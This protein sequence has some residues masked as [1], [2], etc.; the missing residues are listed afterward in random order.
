MRYSSGRTHE[1]K[2][3]ALELAM[4]CHESA[5]AMVALPTLV[6]GDESGGRSRDT[7]LLPGIPYAA[8]LA[9]EPEGTEYSPDAE[10]LATQFD[11]L[12]HRQ[13]HFVKLE[14]AAAFRELDMLHARALLHCTN[15]HPI[16]GAS[17]LELFSAIRSRRHQDSGQHSLAPQQEEDG[18]PASLRPAYVLPVLWNHAIMLEAGADLLE[19]QEAYL[20]IQRLL[21]PQH[22]Q[23]MAD[24]DDMSTPL[25]VQHLTAALRG[26]SASEDAD[27]GEEAEGRGRDGR[28]DFQLVLPGARELLPHSTLATHGFDYKS[29]T[30]TAL[31]R[32]ANAQALHAE[33]RAATHKSQVS[34]PAKLAKPPWFEKQQVEVAVSKASLLHRGAFRPKAPHTLPA[35]GVVRRQTGLRMALPIISSSAS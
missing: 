11:S 9:L 34:N 33:K 35:T 23:V 22:A 20:L 5:Q 15:A 1:E 10:T 3:Q 19:A 13:Y 17:D 26:E 2:M 25:A 24:T 12:Q 27:K 7:A 14:Q 29:E 21:Q 32:L 30:A 16:T 8:R 4:Q 18:R 6:V 31:E 28:L